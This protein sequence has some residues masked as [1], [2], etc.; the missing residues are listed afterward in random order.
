[1]N[2][3]NIN[4]LA[5]QNLWREL[6]SYFGSE[7]KVLVDVPI[8]DIAEINEQVANK[9]ESFREKRVLYIGGGGGKYGQPIICDSEEELERKKI[10]LS[11]VLECR[12]S[13]RGQK[14]L[15]EF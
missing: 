7:I 5:V 11:D 6:V 10:E 9:I 8:I 4:A 15:N 12:S 14:T 13:F 1:M 3:E 2:V